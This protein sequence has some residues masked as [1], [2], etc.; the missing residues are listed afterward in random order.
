[1]NHLQLKCNNIR[2]P[3]GQDMVLAREMAK[4]ASNVFI[5]NI[6]ISKYDGICVYC[7]GS[8]GII[9]GSLFIS[10]YLNSDEPKPIMLYCVKKENERCHNTSSCYYLKPFN[11]IIDD[12]IESG[13]TI[14]RIIKDDNIQKINC[15]IVHN[16][17]VNL[18]DNTK[19]LIDTVIGYYA[20]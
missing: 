19:A 14:E 17:W 8:S 11:I 9:L 20:G 16:G 2:Y 10:Y 7:S 18:D 3:V 6:D 1:M 12:C 4:S 13:R 15:L 5:H